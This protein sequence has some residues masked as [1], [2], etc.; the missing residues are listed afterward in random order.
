MIAM[1]T[2]TGYLTFKGSLVRDILYPKPM[3]FSFYKDFLVFVGAL[4]LVGISGFIAVAPKLVEIG[5]ET[6]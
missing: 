2:R 1:V 5:L 6:D 3:H 4:A